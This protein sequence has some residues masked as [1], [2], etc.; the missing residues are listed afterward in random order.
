M[1]F[2]GIDPSTSSTGYAVVNEKKELM[3]CGRIEG[4]ADDPKSFSHLYK[5]IVQLLT[6]YPPSGITCET[7]FIGPNRETSIKLIRPTGVILAAAGDWDVSFDFL[8]P[9]SWRH[10]YQGAGKWSKRDTYDFTMKQYPELIRRFE[11][12]ALLKNGKTS[13]VRMY[14]NCNDMTD[15]IGI[16]CA[17]ADTYAFRIKEGAANESIN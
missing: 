10:M 16:A 8:A 9:S 3:D 11:P 5:R 7:Q 12:E 14:N 15:A 13:M 2:I 4:L 1:Y 17:C 6:D